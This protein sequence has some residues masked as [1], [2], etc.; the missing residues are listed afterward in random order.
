MM[1]PTVHLNGTSLAELQT[2]LRIAYGAVH[3][4]IDAVSQCAPHGRDYYVQGP[5][6]IGKATAEHRSR[7][8]RLDDVA[9]ELL[10]IGMALPFED[11]MGQTYR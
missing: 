9:N 10:N 1:I 2:A 11:G 6:A 8:D 7:I 3:A 5:D 4:A